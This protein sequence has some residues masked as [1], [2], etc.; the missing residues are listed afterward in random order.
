MGLFTFHLTTNRLNKGMLFNFRDNRHIQLVFL[1]QCVILKISFITIYSINSEYQQL[2]IYSIT[3]KKLSC[4]ESLL[5]GLHLVD[6]A[7]WKMYSTPQ[8]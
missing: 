6:V 3:L 7:I 8:E 1:K 2:C 5:N 4:E